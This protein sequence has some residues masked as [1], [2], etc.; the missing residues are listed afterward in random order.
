MWRRSKSLSQTT[1]ESHVFGNELMA[2][3]ADIDTLKILAAQP[4]IQNRASC[5]AILALH[6]AE[7][8]VFSQFGDDG[9]IQ[10]LIHHLQPLPDTFVEFGV[11]N[12]RESNTRFLLVNN[13]WRGLVLDGDEASINY[14]QHDEIY[15]RHTL[16]ARR[17]FI[18]RDNINDLVREAG[19]TGEIGLLSIDIDGNDYWVWEKIEV[20]NPVITIVEYNSIFGFDLAVTVPYHPKFARHRAHYSGQFWG[21]SLHALKLQGDRKGYSL[22]GCNSAGNNAYFVRSDKVAHLPVLSVQ[23]AFVDARFRDSRDEMGKLTY[24]TGA[25][26]FRAIAHLDVY[27]LRQDRIVPLNSLANR[28]TSS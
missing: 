24:L 18:T 25:E 21:A 17:A 8:K 4:L 14:I 12:Y 27:D 26:R 19:F 10:Y 1:N 15:W 23:E 5:G 28:S 16:T 2:L 13:N 22:L 11:E 6:Q 3:R 7:F 20:L 9:I